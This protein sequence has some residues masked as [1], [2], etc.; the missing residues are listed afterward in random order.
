MI[1]SSLIINHHPYDDLE[2]VL[3]NDRTTGAFRRTEKYGLFKPEH[4][5][6][7]IYMK[8][9]VIELQ[10]VDEIPYLST[11]PKSALKY[12]PKVNPFYWLMYNKL[13]SI[14]IFGCV[15][16]SIV[17]MAIN[18]PQL[19]P[20]E[21]TLTY[22]FTFEV[23]FRVIGLESF[24]Y[25]LKDSWN[26][27]DFMIVLLG[28]IS[29]L[30]ISDDGGI[31]FTS[32]RALRALRVLRAMKFLRGLH[33]I[34][35]TFLHT[36]KQILQVIPLFLFYILLFGVAAHSMWKESLEF[37][38]RGTIHQ[39]CN[40]DTTCPDDSV[41]E[42]TGFS[43]VG[44]DSLGSAM[45]TVYM[46]SARSGFG[47]Y[48]EGLML[49]NSGF[50]VIL[51]FLGLSIFLSS[52]VLA[53]FVAI[54]RGSFAAIR[55][56]N[57]KVVP[58]NMPLVVKQQP[59]SGG[60]W[61]DNLMMMVIMLSCIC[62]ALPSYGQSRTKERFLNVSEVF[63]ASIFVFE[64][65][66]KMLT[67]GGVRKYFSNK[68]NAFDF[69]IVVTS[70][71]DLLVTNFISLSFL[72]LLRLLR[73]IK[74]LRQSPDIVKIVTAITR[75]L[76]ALG[77]LMMFLLLLLVVYSL[78]G[79]Q[80]YGGKFPPSTKRGNFDTFFDSILSLFQ[81]VT[82][83]AQWPLFMAA[84]ATD[85]GSTSYLYFFSFGIFASFILLN[86][87]VVIIMA[88]FAPNQEELIVQRDR[89]FEV[90]WTKPADDGH[91]LFEGFIVVSI[92]LSSVLLTLE[93][94][95]YKENESVHL[96]IQVGDVVFLV[97]F[98]AEFMYKLMKLGHQ[99]FADPWNRLDCFV[100]IVSFVGMFD[101][102]GSFGR[103]LRVGR[104]LRPLRMI[105]RNQNLKVIVDALI[106]S[107]RPVTYMGLLL[108]CFVFIYA[109]I[110]MELFM[111]KETR[112]FD[113]NSFGGG[114]FTLIEILSLKGWNIKLYILMSVSE[115]PFM[116]CAYMI[117]FVY[118][119]SF[120]LMK[121][122]VGVIVNSFRSFSGTLLLTDSQ[123][124]WIQAK[125]A[126][127]NLVPP[128]RSPWSN[129][130]KRLIDSDYF[131]D[132]NGY[133]HVLLL[134]CSILVVYEVFSVVHFS[135]VFI[136]LLGTLEAIR[137]LGHYKIES[138][139]R[140]VQFGT[141]AETRIY[142]TRMY[143]LMT[144]V[145]ML[146][147]SVVAS[148]F[149]VV[150]AMMRLA[151]FNTI[152]WACPKRF[153][154]A[155]KVLVVLEDCMLPM[156]NV[157]LVFFLFL[158]VYSILGVQT[159]GD[160]ENQ[161]RFYSFSDALLT[162]FEIASGENWVEMIPQM[163]NMIAARIYFYVFYFACF[164][165]FTNLYTA[166]VVDTF[167]SKRPIPD[168]WSVDEQHIYVREWAKFDPDF[169]QRILTSRVSTFVRNCEFFRSG[170]VIRTIRHM[171]LLKGRT[172]ISFYDLADIIL[173]VRAKVD[174]LTPLEKRVYMA[175]YA[176]ATSNAAAESLQ[177]RYRGNQVRRQLVSQV[178]VHKV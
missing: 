107:I 82:G 29:E 177:A 26:R 156:A 46:T 21:S 134:L 84:E 119:G 116:V 87:L 58:A 81:V 38:C 105:R 9:T 53:T 89:A 42:P 126:M 49:D 168:L 76:A 95:R 163:G 135:I 66:Y 157:A 149:V 78:L 145:L 50:F 69:V 27:V 74:L 141:R 106:R 23:V 152:K 113:F 24:H 44:F 155:L 32:F 88:N 70:I 146:L 25:Y 90:L 165:V 103:V 16:L 60:N 4:F 65:V 18:D 101:G 3:V 5:Y 34:A 83:G 169:T 109:V 7:T 52:M 45:M 36:F 130:C 37:K 174:D 15:I 31:N 86:F 132:I 79:M 129:S 160:T 59:T 159:F 139:Y 138:L 41:C 57:R 14:F 30:L 33:E 85:L 97:I 178:E 114:F 13:M 100:L 110:G 94:P 153:L 10:V 128:S 43:M 137:F 120:F 112:D 48:T 56:R 20:V 170:A 117:S 167:A 62:F 125:R 35:E 136:P 98:A 171:V 11:L 91:R 172:T 54:I 150:T 143:S 131:V 115:S 17:I 104:I 133:L 71:V 2:Y 75:S 92:L 111:G 67:R 77:N 19:D 124:A 40:G 8:D 122:F 96:V 6:Y 158:F 118:I 151:S 55:S 93:S 173:K 102:G 123:L 12:P 51:Y 164:G 142:W 39:Y 144:L 1:G 99:Y 22:I 148:K 61:F 63:F 72:R 64:M 47:I 28:W 68:W 154:S 73:V 175:E 121:V 80:L 108:F 166:T 147:A 161:G 140:S 127:L 176:N 162:L